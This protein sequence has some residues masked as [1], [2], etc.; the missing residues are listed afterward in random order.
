M[1]Q[2]HKAS[3]RVRE[4]AAAPGAV[5]LWTEPTAVLGFGLSLVRRPAIAVD[6]VAVADVVVA[7]DVAD[8]VADAVESAPDSLPDAPP[9]VVDATEMNSNYPSAWF[10]I[11]S[12]ALNSHSSVA[13]RVVVAGRNSRRPKSDVHS[14][15]C[16]TCEAYSPVHCTVSEMSP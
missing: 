7:A 5:R 8:A 16:Q 1:P 10:E 6:A 15:F 2:Q 12:I 14:T 3:Q 13:R 9:D 11:V 4:F